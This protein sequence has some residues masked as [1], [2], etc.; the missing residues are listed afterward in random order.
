M[1][2]DVL[3]RLNSAV[4]R[5]QLRL[6]SN[7]PLSREE[8]YQVQEALSQAQKALEEACHLG[9]KATQDWTQKHSPVESSC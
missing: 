2:L 3:W 6:V 9:A 8:W 7:P 5:L 1:P 4:T